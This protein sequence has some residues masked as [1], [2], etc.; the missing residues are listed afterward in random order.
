MNENLMNKESIA[1]LK[2]LNLQLPAYYKDKRLEELREALDKSQAFSSEIKD[3][4]K[5][6]AEYDYEVNPGKS[7]AIPKSKNPRVETSKLIADHNILDI[8]NY[9]LNQ[10]REFKKKNR[11]RYFTF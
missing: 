2:S 4:I 8:Y 7:I 5:N 11:H 10:L 9:N 3:R 6:V 1:L